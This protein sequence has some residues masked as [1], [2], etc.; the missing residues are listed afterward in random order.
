MD[1]VSDNLDPVEV[2]VLIDSQLAAGPPHAVFPPSIPFVAWGR[3]ADGEV[4]PHE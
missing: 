3:A 4:L 1:W 2:D